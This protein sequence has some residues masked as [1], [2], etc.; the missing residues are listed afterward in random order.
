MSKVLI[1]FLGTGPSSASQSFREYRTAE[2]VFENPE[3]RKAT[4]FITAAI[5][6]YC[7]CDKIIVLGTTKSMWEECSPYAR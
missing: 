1:S 6:V 5:A 4:S 3:F 2:Y 7:G